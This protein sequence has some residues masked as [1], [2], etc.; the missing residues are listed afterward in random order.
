[1][2]STANDHQWAQYFY[3]Q[4][5]EGGD[6]ASS[7]EFSESV[8]TTTAVATPC[9]ASTSDHHHHN[10]NHLNPK[11]CGSKPVRR[12]SRA[13]KKTPTTLLNANT[14]NF[15]ALVQQFTGCPSTPFPFGSCNKKG[16]VNL[17]FGNHGQQQNY[18]R[19]SASVA[20]AFGNNNNH[21]YDQQQSQPQKHFQ[22]QEQYHH[23]QVYQEDQQS[24]VS[25]D[26]YDHNVVI[27]GSDERDGFLMSTNARSGNYLDIPYGFDMD[28]ISMHEIAAGSAFSS[29]DRNHSSFL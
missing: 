5:M 20:A 22:Q 6:V 2:S 25:F 15:R 26:N 8:I 17:S 21:F 10:L 13:S 14:T 19:Y 7:I 24:L 12:R 4:S 29:A 11:G 27:S 28:E 18:Q 3:H 23:Q 9:N 1:M 16:P